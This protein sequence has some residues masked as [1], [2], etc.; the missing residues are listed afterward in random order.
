MSRE[1]LIQ[2]ASQIRHPSRE[3]AA[4]YAA[5]SE[6][7]AAEM[8]RVFSKRP[9]LESLIGPGNLN[10]MQE[11]HRNHTRFIAALL[12]DFQPEVLV[13]TLLWV[14]RAYRS[15]GFRLAYWPT[16]LEIWVQILKDN[17]QSESFNAV[18]PVYGFM[19]AN[20][21]LIAGLSEEFPETGN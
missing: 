12:M 21:Q 9:D 10:M 6:L 4:E 1:K 3:T 16:Q 8:N 14:F 2:A 17:L 7:L 20:L 15:H 19:I 11:N 5:K 18:Y 13:E